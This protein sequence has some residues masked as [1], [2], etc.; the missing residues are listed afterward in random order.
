MPTYEYFCQVCD[1]EMEAFQSMTAS[2]LRKCPACGKLK[3][4]RK[5]GIG[6]G[7]I[8]KGSG[9]YETD[10]RSESYKKDQKAE[11][12]KAKGKDK[13]KKGDGGGKK[14]KAGSGGGGSESSSKASTDKGGSASSKKNKKD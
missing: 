12:D 3:L 13:D 6:A 4:K 5:I 10:Y 7:I 8:F 9:F 1:H 2:P 11:A 14:E